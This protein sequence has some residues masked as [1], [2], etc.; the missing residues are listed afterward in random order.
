VRKEL[1]FITTNT[2]KVK[3]IRDL[4]E[5]EAKDLTIKHLEYDYPERQYDETE[6]V[7]RESANYIRESRAIKNTFF[8]E[9]S[10]MF[11]PALNGFPGPYSAFVSKSIGNDGILK[12]MA[13][14]KGAERRVTFKTVVAFCDTPEKSPI[15]FVG[16]VEGKIA[17]AMRGEGGFGFDPI[18]E[19]E[20]TTFAEMGIEAKNKVSHRGRAFRKLLDYLS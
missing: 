15:L 9:D 12:L 16:T 7:A 3:E 14:K 11:I 4:V 20:E 17:D 2:H 10:G 1:L 8:I 13:G 6:E 5:A 18:F 19:Y